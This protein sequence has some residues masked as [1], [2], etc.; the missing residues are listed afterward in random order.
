MDELTPAPIGSLLLRM[1][2]EHEREDKVFDLP[3]RKFWHGSPELD[4]SVLSTAAWS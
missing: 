4:T 3:C 2:R 1:L